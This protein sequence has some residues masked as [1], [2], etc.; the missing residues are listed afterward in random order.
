MR[1][2]AGAWS[3]RCLHMSLYTAIHCTIVKCSQGFYTFFFIKG[4]RKNYQS[5]TNRPNGYGKILRCLSLKYTNFMS[6]VTFHKA[7]VKSLFVDVAILWSKLLEGLV[8][9]GSTPC[10]F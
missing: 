10:S 8:P 9:T 6:G 2:R 3:F 5:R 1:V 7:C 4:S